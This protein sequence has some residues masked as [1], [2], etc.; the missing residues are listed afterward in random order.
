LIRKSVP[1]F[2]ARAGN[3]VFGIAALAVFTQLLSP[4]EYGVY[5]LCIA[6]AA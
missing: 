3:G 6:V 5:A 4:E 2:A 1:Y